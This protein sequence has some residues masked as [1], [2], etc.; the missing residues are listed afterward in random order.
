VIGVTAIIAYCRPSGV[1]ASFSCQI[2]INIYSAPSLGANDPLRLRLMKR[3]FKRAGLEVTTTED[4]PWALEA[5]C[6]GRSARFH[7][8]PALDGR[9]LMAEGDGWRLP[10]ADD[11]PI[12][13]GFAQ[14]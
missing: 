13:V 11:C 10:V 9:L 5:G 2:A 3:V 4:G 12:P 8:R 6:L 14:E 1:A 7:L